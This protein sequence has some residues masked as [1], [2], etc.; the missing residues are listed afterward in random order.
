[1]HHFPQKSL[2]PCIYI[3]IHKDNTCMYLLNISQKSHPFKSIPSPNDEAFCTAPEVVPKLLALPFFMKIRQ[4]RLW[5]PC[6]G[7]D[8]RWNKSGT[9]ERGTFR[10]SSGTH[11]FVACFCYI[12]WFDFLPV[13]TEYRI[14]CFMYII[15]S[16]VACQP[17]PSPNRMVPKK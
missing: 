11:F 2:Q 17:A 8:G 4:A 1:M 16:R 15:C 6:Q 5:K 10:N 13:H 3:Y 14:C 9:R 7:K 12:K